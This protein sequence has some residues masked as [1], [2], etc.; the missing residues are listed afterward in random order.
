MRSFSLFH[1][2][3]LVLEILIVSHD[4]DPAYA[5]TG[6]SLLNDWLLTMVKINSVK[7]RRFVVYDTGIVY[8]VGMMVVRRSRETKGSWDKGSW[9][10]VVRQDVMCRIACLIVMYDT[11]CLI[12]IVE[13]CVVYVFGR[14]RS[15]FSR[16]GQVD[17]LLRCCVESHV[18]S[19]CTIQNVCYDYWV[20]RHLC[21]LDVVGLC[22]ADWD[23]LI[24]CYDGCETWLCCLLLL[25]KNPMVGSY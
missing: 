23:G 6:C 15:V 10:R 8:I 14:C 5:S 13:F 9:D 3:A 4:R 21:I 17:P 11:E 2:P 25:K 18:W 24:R 7:N 19:L 22:S 12:A 20:L 16:L 1:K